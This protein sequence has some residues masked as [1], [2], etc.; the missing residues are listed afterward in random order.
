MSSGGI[1]SHDTSEMKT[2]SGIMDENSSYYTDLINKLYLII[3]GFVGSSQFKGGLADQFEEMV[4]SKRQLFNNYAETFDEAA[5]LIR[6]RA[7]YIETDT[8]RLVG[9]IDSANPLG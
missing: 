9:K 6:D 1:Y 3:D 4:L 5:A 8:E 7:D 2:W